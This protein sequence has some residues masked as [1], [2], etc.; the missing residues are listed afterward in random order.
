[1][2]PQELSL[3]NGCIWDWAKGITQHELLH[4]MG[5]HHEQSR[6][7]RDDYVTINFNNIQAGI[8]HKIL[9]TKNLLKHNRRKIKVLTVLRIRAPLQYTPYG[10]TEI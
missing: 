5:L 10:L 2:K 7:D 1:M 9:N 8:Y 3:D 4:A 6:S